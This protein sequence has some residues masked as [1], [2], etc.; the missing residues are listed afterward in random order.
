M[1]KIDAFVI[2]KYRS[3]YL[4]GKRKNAYKSGYFGFPGGRLH[5]GETIHECA[6]RELAEEVNLRA[7]SLRFIGVIRE[8]QGKYD[9]IHFAFFC[10]RFSGK[11]KCLEPDKCEYWI[12]T[13]G[14]KLIAPMLPAHRIAISLLHTNSYQS[15]SFVYLSTM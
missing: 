5:T 9:F 1:Q 8:T 13:D 10:N 4:L 11:V 15:G 3:R 12:W 14:K 2:V 6:V 7:T